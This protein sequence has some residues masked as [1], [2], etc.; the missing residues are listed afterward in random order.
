MSHLVLLQVELVEVVGMLLQVGGVTF[1]VAGG[2]GE[3]AP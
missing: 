2:G 3:V 1:C